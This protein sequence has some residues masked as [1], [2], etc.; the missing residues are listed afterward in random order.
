MRIEPSSPSAFGAHLDDVSADQIRRTLSLASLDHLIALSAD[1]QRRDKLIRG[2]S[3]AGKELVWRHE[4][5]K[6]LF[7]RDFERAL[8][9]SLKRAMRTFG[10]DCS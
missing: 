2:V 1:A 10:S 4:N 6:R 3:R 5:E 9:L 7:P 8:L